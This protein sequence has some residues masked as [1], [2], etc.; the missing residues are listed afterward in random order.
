MTR[1]VVAIDLTVT[2]VSVC[3]LTEGSAPR[4]AGIPFTE[5]DKGAKRSLASENKRHA[6]M[7]RRVAKAIVKGG[8]P[9]LV[10]LA[11]PTFGAGADSRGGGTKA[12]DTTAYRRLGIFWALVAELDAAG[13]PVAELGVLAAAKALTHSGHQKF[14]GGRVAE[15][16]RATFPDMAVPEDK[17]YRLSTVGLAV[18]GALAVGIDVEGVPATEFIYARLRAGGDFPESVHIPRAPR[19]E[20]AAKADKDRRTTFIEK[21]KTQIEKDK[22]AD[23]DGSREPRNPELRDL[24][25]KRLAR[26]TEHIETAPLSD[27]EGYKRPTHPELLVV[28]KRRMAREEEREMGRTRGET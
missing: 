10:V 3:R 27:L 9:E 8:V 13:I 26:E 12:G 18:C 20:E 22:W 21:R 4:P 2:Y 1:S 7:A 15:W 23:L 24:W 17:L 5:P 6:D 11:R 16:V 14:A 19:S 25:R 28:W